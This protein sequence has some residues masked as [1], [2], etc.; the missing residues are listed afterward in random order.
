MTLTTSYVPNGRS[1]SAGANDLR[2]V[3]WLNDTSPL[4]AEPAADG[5]PN[6]I[7]SRSAISERRTPAATPTS[8]L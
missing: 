6:S 3:P 1:S 4:I 7:E 5:L 8:A 2:T